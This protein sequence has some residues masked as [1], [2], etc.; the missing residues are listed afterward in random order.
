MKIRPGAVV[1]IVATQLAGCSGGGS[2]APAVPPGPH[3]VTLSWAPNHEKGV[4]SVGGGYH[5]SI[6]TQPPTIIDVPFPAPPS[7]TTILQT[8]TYTVTLTAFATLDA[9]GGSAGSV[10]APSQLTVNVP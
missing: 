5:V 9:Q 10:S 6:S 3:N 2:S 8:G 1:L 4:N 7:I